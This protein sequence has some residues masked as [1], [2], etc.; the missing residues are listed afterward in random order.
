M[1]QYPWVGQLDPWVGQLDPGGVEMAPW[2]VEVAPWVVTL[3]PWGHEQAPRGQ[4]S[5]WQGQTAARGP[6]RWPGKVHFLPQ[7]TAPPAPEGHGRGNPTLPAPGA[8][9][10]RG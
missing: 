2:V 7:R 3:D 10:V 6:S 8:Y 5:P 1:S 9:G 4:S